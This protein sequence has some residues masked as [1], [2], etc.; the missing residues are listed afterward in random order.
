MLEELTVRS[1]AE[2]AGIELPRPF[3]RLSYADAMA[4]YGSDRPDTRI[5]LELVD[6]TDAFRTSG[7]RAFRQASRP[8]AS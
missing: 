3:Q 1:C 8:A 5:Q 4:R 6:L 2:A 7:F